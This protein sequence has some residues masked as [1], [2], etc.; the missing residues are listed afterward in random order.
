MVNRSVPEEQE[1][2]D[3]FLLTWS[4]APTT[5]SRVLFA[6]ELSCTPSGA[7]KPVVWRYPVLRELQG[8][9]GLVDNRG[10]IPARLWKSMALKP[11]EVTL[12]LRESWHACSAH[13]SNHESAG[14]F[15]GLSLCF[16]SPQLRPVERA[17]MTLPLLQATS[18]LTPATTLPSSSPPSRRS[19]G[20]LPP[21]SSKPASISPSC[22]AVLGSPKCRTRSALLNSSRS[23]SQRRRRQPKEEREIG[24]SWRSAGTG[25]ARTIQR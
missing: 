5:L 24:R 3:S 13:A 16:T 12:L 2:P 20:L 14:T 25:R 7:E 9:A 22:S 17:E 18:T 1:R 19:S 11:A 21:I 23:C 4:G 6:I 15:P 8:A 10:V